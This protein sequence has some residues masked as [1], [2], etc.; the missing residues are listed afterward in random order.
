MKSNAARHLLVLAFLP[1]L[2]LASPAFAQQ[3]SND[4]FKG[5]Q[6]GSKGPVN[7][8]A[9]SL[10]VVEK[11]GQRISTFSGNVTVTRGDSVLKASKISIFSAA[12]KTPAATDASK[13]A[14]AA[15]PADAPKPPE[16][17]KPAEPPKPAAGADS[18]IL[19]GAGSFTRIEASG[20]VYVASGPQ[21]A[22]GDTA[23]VDMVGKLV[24]L[25]GNVVLSQG[26]NVLTGDKL[27]W[28][29][30]TGKARVE[31]KPGGRIRG[32]F[33]PNSTPGAKP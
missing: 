25:T 27:T 18:S 13:P 30:T 22:T 31:Q 15:K 20:K 16:P 10:D 26:P 6:T 19:P 33:M 3:A 5:F 21:T 23:V 17:A 1:M 28:D 11:G 29:M 24:T 7:V 8:E 2:G 4:L 14:D 9:D 12:S 32:I